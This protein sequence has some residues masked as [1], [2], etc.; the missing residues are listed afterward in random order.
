MALHLREK[1]RKQ[2]DC[3]LDIMRA[4]RFANAV[5]APLR[6]AYIH[7]PNTKFGTEGRTNGRSTRRVILHYEFLHFD[8]GV[9][10]EMANE[11]R[12]ARCGRI[13]L[14]CIVL[15]DRAMV[16]GRAV[17]RL[18]LVGVVWVQRVCHVG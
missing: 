16:E 13:P 3:V 18:V 5:H 9:C 1:A 6:I 2:L 8:A 10:S 17:F 12:R 11:V 7:S 15:D 4:A 14:V